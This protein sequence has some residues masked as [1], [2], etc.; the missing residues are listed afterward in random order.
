MKYKSYRF[1]LKLAIEIKSSEEVH[2]HHMKGLRAFSEEFPEARLIIF[3]RDKYARQVNGIEIYPASEFLYM[4]WK[5]A[6]F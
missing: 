2:S 1:Y 3:S 6:L 5:G 4:L